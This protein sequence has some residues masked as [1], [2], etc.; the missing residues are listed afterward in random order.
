MNHQA[1]SPYAPPTANLDSGP[2]PVSALTMATARSRL[3]ALAIDAL[4]LLPGVI[5]MFLLTGIGPGGG[6]TRTPLAPGALLPVIVCAV[7]V[8]GA[9][10]YQIVILSNRGQTLGKRA[11]KI[12]IVKA[13][14]SKPGFLHAFLLRYLVNAL[15]R[16][17][18]VVGVLYPLL[19][20]LFVLRADRRCVHDLIAGTR[21]VQVQAPSPVG[22]P[23]GL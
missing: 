15:P 21:V 22:S 14:G 1:A 2:T 6:Q 16:A 9:F 13:D 10:A 17:I 8:F 12:C 18:P 5:G 11:M 20:G 7:Y 3:A 19:D 4:V 23:A